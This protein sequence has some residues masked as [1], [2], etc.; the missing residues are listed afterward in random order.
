M[1]LIPYNFEPEFTEEEL[2]EMTAVTESGES[3]KVEED[4]EETV[5]KCMQCVF[6]LA[7]VVEERSCCRSNPLTSACSEALGENK[8]ITHHPSFEAVVLNTSVLETAF[9]QGL[10]YKKTT[11][12][13]F[14]TALQNR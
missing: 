10:A 3:S 6:G 1:D 12:S 2:R 14:P 11:R 9:V 7:I 8:C 4:E 5:C 13:R